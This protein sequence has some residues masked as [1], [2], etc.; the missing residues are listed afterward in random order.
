MTRHLGQRRLTEAV[1]RI[2]SAFS[3]L[4]RNGVE[5]IAEGNGLS[6]VGSAQVGE[7]KT[8]STRLDGR[9]CPIASPD[10]VIV[11]LEMRLINEAWENERVFSLLQ[12]AQL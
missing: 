10:D 6:M 8:C 1:T 2:M 12:Q 3:Q 11:W 4:Y 7:I 9:T 5:I